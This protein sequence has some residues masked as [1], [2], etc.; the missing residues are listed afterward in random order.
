MPPIDP[1]KRKDYNRKYYQN[2]KKQK[3]IQLEPDI[4]FVSWWCKLTKVNNQFREK[5][6]L[7]IWIYNMK[8]CF[9]EMRNKKLLKPKIVIKKDKIKKLCL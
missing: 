6:W 7:P 2:K 8:S 9:Q 1:N 3:Q 5:S 4:D